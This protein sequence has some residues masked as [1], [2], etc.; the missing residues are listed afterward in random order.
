MKAKK[1]I[2]VAGVLVAPDTVSAIKTSPL[3][4]G[5]VT[6]AIVIIAINCAS[7]IWAYSL[8]LEK[9]THETNNALGYAQHA[10][11]LLGQCTQ[12]IERALS[13]VNDTDYL[14]LERVVSLKQ[15]SLVGK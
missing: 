11:A 8:G 10:T 2:A 15:I 9:R 4:L 3:E 12:T 7:V 13:V 6:W 1:I 14:L 5:R